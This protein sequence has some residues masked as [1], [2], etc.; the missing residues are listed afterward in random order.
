MAKKGII[1]PKKVD[2]DS[3]PERFL[4]FVCCKCKIESRNQRGLNIYYQKEV[5]IEIFELVV[6]SISKNIKRSFSQGI[7]LS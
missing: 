4:N 6:L 2:Q 3:A 1:V 5:A 7:E